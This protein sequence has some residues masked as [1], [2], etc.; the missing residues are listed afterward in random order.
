MSANVDIVRFKLACKVHVLA[1]FKK[2]PVSGKTYFFFYKK[3][4]MVFGSTFLVSN[5]L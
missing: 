3:W 2:F 4:P 5:V 1:Y